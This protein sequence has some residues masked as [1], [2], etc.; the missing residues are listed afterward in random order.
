[1]KAKKLILA[2]MVLIIGSVFIFRS[3]WILLDRMPLM[4]KDSVLW[5]F[6][7]IGL[8]ISVWALC[9]MAGQKK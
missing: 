6:L 5:L 9:C 2:E 8:A 1:M 4:N 7:L 3:M